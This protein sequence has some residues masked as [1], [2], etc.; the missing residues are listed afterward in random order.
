M[1]LTGPDPAQTPRIFAKS[2]GKKQ[3]PPLWHAAVAGGE[4]GVCVWV[5]GGV[6]VCGGGWLVVH[7]GCWEDIWFRLLL[8]LLAA[9]AITT[10]LHYYHYYSYYYYYYY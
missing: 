5:C 6:V 2:D 3:L 10:V 8:L 7:G 9:A 4:E 1:F